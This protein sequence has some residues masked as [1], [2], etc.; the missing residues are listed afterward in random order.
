MTPTTSADLTMLLKS[1]AHGTD[2]DT[3]QRRYDILSNPRHP[4]FRRVDNTFRTTV[5]AYWRG[6]A[7]D[8]QARVDEQTEATAAN[9]ERKLI[10]SDI[11]IRIQALQILMGGRNA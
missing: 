10:D 9:S 8:Q 7:E 1:F 11:D 4:H 5:A 3:G 6:L 2:L